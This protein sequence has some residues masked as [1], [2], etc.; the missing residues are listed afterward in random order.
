M[1]LEAE[2]RG[3]MESKFQSRK[4]DACPEVLGSG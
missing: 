4:P 3:E 2:E 1:Q